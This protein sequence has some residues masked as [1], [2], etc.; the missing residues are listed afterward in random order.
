M[1]AFLET[2]NGTCIFSNTP[3]GRNTYAV[4]MHFCMSMVEGL[5]TDIRCTMLS[6]WLVCV[7]LT[8]LQLLKLR[9]SFSAVIYVNYIDIICHR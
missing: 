3:Q 5:L 7:L 2:C 6:M 8:D 4:V 1:H 9:P